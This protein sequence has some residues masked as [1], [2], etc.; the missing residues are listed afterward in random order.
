MLLKLTLQYHLQSILTTCGAFLVKQ[1]LSLS[2]ALQNSTSFS[3]KSKASVHSKTKYS[4]LVVR[5]IISMSG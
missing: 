4:L 5:G 1:E 2:L 3:I